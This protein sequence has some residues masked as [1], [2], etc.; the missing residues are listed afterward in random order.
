MDNQAVTFD[1]EKEIEEVEVKSGKRKKNSWE[2][3]LLNS[4]R[5]I[6]LKF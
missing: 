2:E 3:E 5:V 1:K 6:K 4:N